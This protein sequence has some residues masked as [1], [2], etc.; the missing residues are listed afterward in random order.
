ML[1]NSWRAAKSPD[2]ELRQLSH[3][4]RAQYQPLPDLKVLLFVRVHIC[5]D[6]H[7]R[8]LL[9]NLEGKNR[10]EEVGTNKWTER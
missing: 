6:H 3:Q 8:I 5:Q 2:A 7:C 9:N 1:P 10:G 4:S